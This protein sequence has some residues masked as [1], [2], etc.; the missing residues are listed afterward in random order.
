[1]KT[2]YKI[3]ASLSLLILVACGGETKIEQKDTTEIEVEIAE[4]EE[5]EETEETHTE[6]EKDVESAT[7][8]EEESDEEESDELS[9]EFANALKDAENYLN[10]MPMSKAGLF[11]Q[12]TSE[13]GSGYPE[14]AA[15]YAVDTVDADWKENALQ[16][17]R[18][19]LEYMAMS[20]SQLYEQLVSEHGSQYTDEEA[21]YAIDN[22]NAEE[23]NSNVSS[24][25]NKDNISREFINALKSAED[26][27]NFMPMSKAGLFDQL[28]SEHGAGYPED[29]ARYAID[30]VKTNWKE[31]ALQSA[32]DYLDFMPMS[33]N[34]LYNQLV[35]EHGAQYT[36]EEAQYAIDNLD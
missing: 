22:I 36:H 23:E 8:L 34:E 14:D 5:I 28:T 24:A 4:A 3:F 18:D 30:N 15:Q 20:D 21:Q 33:D 29:A 11:E 27:L 9:R 16:S 1:M 19:Y 31:N 2:I 13:Y 7:E 17:A 10:F 26:Y 6:G 32:K 35:S 12:L 25:K